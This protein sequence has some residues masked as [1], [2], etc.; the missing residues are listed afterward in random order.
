[1]KKL[2]LAS[3]ALAAV[4]L[5]PGEGWAQAAPPA[6]PP[7]KLG[8]GGYFQFYGIF[9]EQS[10]H[11]FDF[12]R[13]GE[14]WFLGQAKLDN[15]LMIGVDVQLEASSCTDQIDESY[16]WF[17]GGWGRVILG[18]ENS[19]AY[20][21]SVG[22]PTVDANFDGQD[23]NYRLFNTL[24]GFPGDP[25]NGAT[26]IAPGAGALALQNNAI[27][28][29]VVNLSTDAEKITYLSPRI[30]G[31][32]AGLSFTPDNSEDGTAA[33]TTA[34]GGSFAGML[35]NNN[36]GMYSNIIGFGA[37]YEGAIGPA[38]LLAGVSYE[39]GWRE[40]DARIGAS[41][42]FK[43]RREAYSVGFD[44]GFAGVH[45]GA[46]YYRDDNGFRQRGDHSAW[47][48]GLTYTMGP[49]TVGANYFDSQRDVL[50][51]TAT[52]V[53][54]ER[55]RRLLVGGRYVLGPGIDIRSSVHYYGYNAPT[56]SDLAD[57]HAWF[58]VL[59][60]NFTF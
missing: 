39:T 21:L 18:S 15:G 59:G 23:P 46:L 9:G 29:S 32:R 30:F 55:L 38:S 51:A 17:Q 45:F 27:D 48:V 7:I 19:A 12:K 36:I 34:K 33:S 28:A 26:F 16:I 47:A 54:D 20:L 6:G 52:P 31:F 53:P 5:A 42:T 44:V 49:L 41:P 22:S 58:F 24:A 4:A 25:R 40:Q 10:R 8:L 56:T 60:T 50:S 14:I 57:N 11:N 1:M 37:N 13:E 2:L 43:D 35:P 3:T